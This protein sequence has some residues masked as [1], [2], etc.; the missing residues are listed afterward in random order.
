VTTAMWLARSGMGAFPLGY[1]Y[2][3][4]AKSNCW[5]PKCRTLLARTAIPFLDG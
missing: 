2:R 1:G 5:K 3:R 4:Q